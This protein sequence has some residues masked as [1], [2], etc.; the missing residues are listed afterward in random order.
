MKTGK[1]FAGASR[2]LMA[3]INEKSQRTGG[4]GKTKK[5]LRLGNP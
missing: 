3:I 4:G 1:N 2:G 5:L